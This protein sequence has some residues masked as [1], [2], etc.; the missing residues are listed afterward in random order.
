MQTLEVAAT[1]KSNKEIG[2]A[3]NI[4]EATVKIDMTH[5]MDKLKVTGR[6][7]ALNVAVRRGLIYMDTTTAA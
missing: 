6:T 4:S 3:L 7:E 2:V 5:I 1:G